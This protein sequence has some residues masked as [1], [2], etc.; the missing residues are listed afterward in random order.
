MNMAG[1]FKTYRQKN[2][3]S[4][5]T[6]RVQNSHLKGFTGWCIKQNIHPPTITHHGVLKFIDSERSRKICKASVIRIVNSVKI[7]FDYLVDTKAIR[8]NIIRQIKLR[9]EGKR[10]L[11]ELLSGQ[12][13]DKIYCD[14]HNIPQWHHKSETIKLLHQRNTVALGLLIYQG[15]DS[16]EITKLETEH[17]DLNEGKIYIPSGKKSNARTLKLQAVQIL[18]LK[19]YVEE[20]KP[21]LLAKRKI[22]SSYLFPVKKSSDLVCK[23]IEQVKKQHP[24]IKDRRQ[25]RASV[26]MNWLK[27]YNIRQVQYMAG[28]KSIRS[29][30]SYR[31]QDLTDL[32]KQLE[33][34]HPLR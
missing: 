20:I 15:L 34:L 4:E 26:I 14:Y 29:T 17:I 24:E 3:Y 25:I 10:V 31:E 9:S 32:S 16:G 12:Q 21:K 8:Q 30:E 2:G 5:K 22:Q 27:Q 6:I 28:H 13:L 11:P 19:I 33:R 23:I 18:P 1:E 7:Y